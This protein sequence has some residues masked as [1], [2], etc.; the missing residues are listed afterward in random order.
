MGDVW[1]MLTTTFSS[2]D[3]FTYTMMA[4]IIVGAALM[5]PSM[6]AI[7]TATCGGLAVF[8][9]AIFLRTVLASK[10]GPSVAREN[11]VYSLSLPFSTI[12]L[13]GGV[14]CFSIAIAYSLRMAA[15]K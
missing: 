9:L 1:N 11:L 8:A 15:K 7:V 2:F 6:A 12:L 10:N 14:F 13:Y 4:I 3:G 5:M